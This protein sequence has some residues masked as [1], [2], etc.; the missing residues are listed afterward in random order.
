MNNLKSSSSQFESS[1]KLA[2]CRTIL[3]QQSPLGPSQQ[4]HALLTLLIDRSK[5]LMSVYGLSN[6][7]IMF[8]SELINNFE[9]QIKKD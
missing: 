9:G 6:G 2:N 8:V 3:Q 4:Q 5:W 7:S 1:N